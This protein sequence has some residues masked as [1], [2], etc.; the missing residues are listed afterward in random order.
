M[1]DLFTQQKELFDSI[2]PDFSHVRENLP[3]NKEIYVKQKKR[4]TR[5]ARIIF[6]CM[7]E[8]QR[9]TG[10]QCAQGIICNGME[11]RKSIVEYRKRFQEIDIE[12]RKVGFELVEV[13]LENGCKQKYISPSDLNM[14]RELYDGMKID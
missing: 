7:L 13:L 14:V 6:A 11:Q 9:I 4:L 12:L 8:G 1:Q 2:Q 10:L 5:N 3:A